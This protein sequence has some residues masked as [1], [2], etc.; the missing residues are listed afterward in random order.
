MPLA[1]VSAAGEDRS[2][3]D[4]TVAADG[5]GRPDPASAGTPAEFVDAMRRL[6]DWSGLAYRQ[7]EKR[8]AAAGDA[9]PRS[10]LTVALTRDALPREQLV[11]ALA[12][13]CGCGEDEVGQWVAARRRIAAGRDVPVTGPAGPATVAPV[14][15]G[16]VPAGV[17]P[18]GRGRDLPVRA[19]LLIGLVALT[20]VAAVTV[21]G[22]VAPGTP[23]GA[24]ADR[25]GSSAPSAPDPT[26]GGGPSVGPRWPLPDSSQLRNPPPAPAGVPRI[27]YVGDSLATETRNAVA[28]FV[29]RSGRAAVV[30]ADHPGVAICDYLTGRPAGS[31]VPAE[32]RLSTLVRD[33]RPRVVV[34]QFGMRSRGPATCTG[35]DP[36]GADDLRRWWADAQ[37]A[38]RQVTEAA[39]AAGIARPALVWVLQAPDR[40]NPQRIRRLNEEIFRAVATAH[41]DLV[42]DA[43]W[44]VSLA[45]YPYESVPD[46]RYR[47][48]QF[49]PCT[50]VERQY[51][52][53]TAPKAFGGVARLHRE[54]DDV[55]FCLGTMT[56]D[57][58]SCDT[59]SPGLIRYGSAIA[60]TLAQYL[61][62]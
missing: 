25:R 30:S 37:E 43:G 57:P 20:V 54:G 62:F 21:R 19:M 22:L 47:W 46:G 1:D 55:H 33:V 42:S 28:F 40:E 58:P 60:D 5:A 32:H 61:G 39:Q 52:Y 51:G 17:V 56:G 49:L 13:T 2:T 34:M 6:K 50:D 7:L 27:L 9:L 35:V 29:H 38:V 3:S 45:A 11:E 8:A 36:P 31:L 15:A 12:R 18:P 16:P 41:G 24:T 14:P 23:D 26:G 53:C 4:A 48:T 44:P 10:T 59:A